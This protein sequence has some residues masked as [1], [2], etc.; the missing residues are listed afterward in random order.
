MREVPTACEAVPV[1]TP[2]ATGSVMWHSLQ[3]IGEMIAPVMPVIM[4]DATVIAGRPPRSL[5]TSMP[6][7]IVI[8]LGVIE[9]S[10]FCEMPANFAR[11]ITEIMLLTLPTKIPTRI[12]NQFALSLSSCL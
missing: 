12:G 2:W 5:E 8:D 11:T 6:I 7:G 10:M 4:M 1:A 3:T 9:T